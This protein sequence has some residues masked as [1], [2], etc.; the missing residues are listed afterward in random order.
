MKGV[1][2]RLCCGTKATEDKEGSRTRDRKLR[3]FRSSA[4]AAA[5][6]SEATPSILATASQPEQGERHGNHHSLI[7][8]E[9]RQC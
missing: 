3:N 7:I 2:F 5:L 1:G 8:L 6:C 9:I 4:A